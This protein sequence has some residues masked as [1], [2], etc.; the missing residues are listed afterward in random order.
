M[1]ALFKDITS[2]RFTNIVV[3]LLSM[4][5]IT[6]TAFFSQR[7][8]ITITAD[9]FSQFFLSINE[10][11]YIS[12]FVSF[13]LILIASWMLFKLNETTTLTL[14]RSNLPF[15]FLSLFFLANPYVDYLS[16][17]IIALLGMIGILFYIFNSYMKE[18]SAEESFMTGVLLGIISLFWKNALLYLPFIIVGLILIRSLSFRSLLAI[19][20][21]IIAI[22]W[23]EFVYYFYYDN[24]EYYLNSYKTLADFNFNKE[25]FIV[26][27]PN[28][29]L[30]FTTFLSFISILI[31]VFTN[32][33]KVKT[34]QCN[35]VIVIGAALSMIFCYL[36]SS[37]LLC[38][39][40]ILYTFISLLLANIFTIKQSNFSIFLFVLINIA[41]L[42]LYIKGLFGL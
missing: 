27:T 15:W 37:S 22:Q 39:L 17:G 40:M 2:G 31:S 26:N 4:L 41:S 34:Q 5:V 29:I 13:T 18:K 24:V 14:N 42:V 36:N 10:N 30:W 16:Q 3:L 12:T 38:H 20:I 35:V 6:F 25:L 32:H 1:A 7:N 11:R 28:I 33:T 23:T 19:F 21:G 8:Y 9:N